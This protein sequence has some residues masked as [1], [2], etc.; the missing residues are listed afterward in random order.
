MENESAC[1]QRFK[2]EKYVLMLFTYLEN[3]T[4]VFGKLQSII[5][6]LQPIY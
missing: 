4:T 3:V 1:E 2:N 5:V 6:K